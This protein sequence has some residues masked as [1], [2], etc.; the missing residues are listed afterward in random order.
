MQQ[1][2]QV[3]ISVKFLFIYSSAFNTFGPLFTLFESPG[4][5][6]A[7]SRSRF[8]SV[9]INLCSWEKKLPPKIELENVRLIYMQGCKKEIPDS[10]I[11]FSSIQGRKTFTKQLAR[12]QILANCLG[13]KRLTVFM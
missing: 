10:I 11:D 2:Y 8:L 6:K 3:R 4:I 7:N 1:K 13:Q 5:C 9:V 12:P